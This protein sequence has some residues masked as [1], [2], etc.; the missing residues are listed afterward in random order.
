VLK[1]GGEKAL[2]KHDD[3]LKYRIDETFDTAK[4][5]IT[6]Q[7]VD[8]TLQLC[9][10]ECVHFDSE[11]HAAAAPKNRVV[12]SKMTT[13]VQ[14]EKATHYLYDLENCHTTEKVLNI[15]LGLYQME[16]C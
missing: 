9:T 10:T 1:Y 13:K 15:D 5:E 14:L 8:N 6:P 7:L 4:I 11:I 2:T 3:L 12:Q 16:D